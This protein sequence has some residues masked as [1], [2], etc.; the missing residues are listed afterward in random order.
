MEQFLPPPPQHDHAS[1]PIE[2][3]NL[4]VGYD[5]RQALQN[6][7]FSIE[8]AQRVAVVGPNGSGKTTLFKVL[9]GTLSPDRLGIPRIRCRRCD[10]ESR[11]QDRLRPLAK[12]ER[13]D[14]GARII[15]Q[16]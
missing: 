9:A 6:I 16:S 1:S 15:A 3:K 5:G 13:L 12:K 11:P 2:V 4:S 8:Q 7:S 14:G 10:D